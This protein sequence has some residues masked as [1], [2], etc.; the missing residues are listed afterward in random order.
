[1]NDF[2]F[3]MEALP[4]NA[5]DISYNPFFIF[6]AYV[7]ALITIYVAFET[8]ERLKTSHDSP[9][10]KRFWWAGGS[11]LFGAGLWSTY[12]V[13]MVSCRL[14]VQVTFNVNYLL[15]A[16]SLDIIAAFAAYATVKEPKFSWYYYI[17]GSAIFAIAHSASH[18]M[19]NYSMNDSIQ[20]YHHRLDLFISSI[21]TVS[22]S[23]FGFWQAVK[24][25]TSYYNQHIKLRLVTS[26]LLAFIPLVAA[27]GQM[28]ALVFVPY[29]SSHYNPNGDV[30]WLVG[31]SIAV[32]MIT[33]I[34]MSLLVSIYRRLMTSALQQKNEELLRK[35]QE[36]TNLNNNLERR[37]KERTIELETLYNNLEE[38]TIKLQEALT[39][40]EAAN[41]AKSIFLANMSHELRTPL[42]A[43][44]GLSELLVEELKEVNEQTYLE[45]VIRI[46]NAGKH[47]LSLISNI[48]D[49]SKIEA[50]KMELYIEPFNCRTIIDELFIVADPLAKKN[51]N[52]L[53]FE[54][55][56]DI[57]EMHSDVTK[58]RQ[59]LMNLVGNAC[60]FTSHG[61]ISLKVSEVH[62]S[63]GSAMVKFIVQDNG[64]GI[65]DEKISQLFNKFVQADSSTTKKFGGAG[66]GLAITKKMCELMGGSIDIQSE[67][68]KGTTLTVL[69]PRKQQSLSVAAPTAAAKS[70]PIA[71]KLVQKEDLKILVI[72][73]NEVEQ[74]L[75]KQYLNSAGY[76]ASFANSGEEGLK[77]A[78]ETPPDVVILDIFL[79]KM[80]GFEVLQ[81]LKQE[82]S[83]AS[84]TIIM[85]S[86]LEEKQKGYV[87]GASDYLVKPF[88]QKQLLEVLN[89]YSTRINLKSNDLGRVLIVDDDNNA[90]FILRTYFDKFKAD[91]VEATNGAEALESI[92][93]KT[94]DLIILDLMMPVMDGFE[95]LEKLKAK[96]EW[97]SIPV[98]INTAKEL[99]NG[100]YNMLSGGVIKILH[101]DEKNFDV[102]GAEII[103]VLK[104][105]K[106]RV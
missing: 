63:N 23:Y 38:K 98:I 95:V 77:L 94:P 56:D 10:L 61:L 36:L 101:K 68:G 58:F 37:V 24:M 42:N 30:I 79:P 25:D 87:M 75:V 90:R 20:I 82:P 11:I 88:N 104:A 70:T 28:E 44:I 27:I 4:S 60:K 84:A 74:Q 39:L 48:L 76:K 67:E 6:L 64:V 100:D 33:I 13:V 52:T 93:E 40:A 103:R 73:D 97:S 12:F 21:L 80:N 53:V 3:F 85:T 14:P 96:E 5:I 72:E 32:I 17:I 49:L 47:L 43:I 91:I 18:I 45:P 69:L 16:I 1:M 86:V 99:E 55:A 29:E 54:C 102:I 7:I 78:L 62:D 51:S 22:G 66:L 83:T 41:Q 9:R 89:R 34:A 106:A 71:L 81:T 50:G 57:G 8:A 35:E 19:N 92:A 26:I 105:I 65:S 59:I 31:L 15:F 2:K 46:H